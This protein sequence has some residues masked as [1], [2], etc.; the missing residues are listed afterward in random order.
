MPTARTTFL[1]ASAVN[2]TIYVIGGIRGGSNSSTVEA[3]D[4]AA[5]AW[6]K[7]EDMPDQRTFLATSTVNGKIYAIGGSY[8]PSSNVSSTLEYTPPTV[9]SVE[10]R[11]TEQ[12]FPAEFVLF[13]NYPNPFNPETTIRYEVAKPGRTLLMVINMLGQVVRTLVDENQPTGFYEVMWDGKDSRET[14]VA[15]GVY[16]YRLEARDLVRTRKMVL[17]Q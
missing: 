9:T 7:R 12:N 2:G 1:A 14:R 13:P 8:L 16:L 4:P 17:L 3:Y 5:N 6:T 10:D 11:F 15:S